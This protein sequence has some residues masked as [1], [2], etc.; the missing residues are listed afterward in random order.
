MNYKA[1]VFV[2]HWFDHG[3]V[4]AT[5]PE[6]EAYAVSI[7]TYPYRVSETEDGVNY[8]WNNG[9]TPYKELLKA[10]TWE[11]YMMAG[12]HGMPFRHW[13]AAEIL[14]RE[15]TVPAVHKYPQ[16]RQFMIPLPI[17]KIPG[18]EVKWM[19][20]P[21]TITLKCDGCGNEIDQDCCGCGDS[22]ADHGSPISC[23]HMPVPMGCDCFRS[24]RAV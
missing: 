14:N 24:D 13:Y 22:M 19:E 21:A 9:L 1:E 4:F 8:S 3:I 2:G 16:I 11:A 10:V 7:R 6:A 20:Q 5:K 12:G 23:G 17:P 18:Y 15:F